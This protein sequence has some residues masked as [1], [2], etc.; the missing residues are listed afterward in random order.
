MFKPTIVKRTTKNDVISKESALKWIYVFTTFLS[1]FMVAWILIFPSSWLMGYSKTHDEIINK[2][3]VEPYD[4]TQIHPKIFTKYAGHPEVQFTHTLP[5]AV[6]STAIPFQ[7]HQGFRKTHKVAHRR[8][9][10]AFLGSSLLMTAGMLIILI[11]KLTFDYDYEGLAPPLSKFEEFQTKATLLVMGLWFAYTSI[12]AVVEARNK[13][14][15]SHKHFIYRHIGSG[16][17]VAV[18]RVILILSGP[19]KNPEAMREFFGLAALMGS[20]VSYSLCE[21]AIYLD[22]QPAKQIKAN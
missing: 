5:A 8:A 22:R 14:F 9:G 2:T 15:Q 17:W 6:W 21:L 10:Y 18:Q 7:L 4:G 16:L 19:Q 13:R 20:V 11:K 1:I 3:M 12:R